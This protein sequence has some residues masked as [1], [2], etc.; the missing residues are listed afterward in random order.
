MTTSKA[1][2]RRPG[3]RGEDSDLGQEAQRQR[4]PSPKSVLSLFPSLLCSQ[5]ELERKCRQRPPSPLLSLCLPQV[6]SFFVISFSLISP[7]PFSPQNQIF[8]FKYVL[9]ITSPPPEPDTT[10]CAAYGPNG[11]QTLTHCSP[12]CS[13]LSCTLNELQL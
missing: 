6:F 10:K 5:R 7:F 1:K 13:L 12:V 3:K 8:F 4:S 11:N 9:L 2:T